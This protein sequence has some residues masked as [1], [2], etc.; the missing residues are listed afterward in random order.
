MRPLRDHRLWM[1]VAV[2][3]TIRLSGAADLLTLNTLRTVG[4]ALTAWV[5]ANGLLVATA[6]VGVYIS[7]GAAAARSAAV[8]ADWRL[9]VRCRYACCLPW[10][11]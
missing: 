11:R 1:M 3:V 7:D 10:L 9:P 6:Y 4:S 5:A 8:E 2:I